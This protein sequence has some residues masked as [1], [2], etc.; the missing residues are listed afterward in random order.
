M[1]QQRFFNLEK[2]LSINRELCIAYHKFMSE[3]LDMSHVELVTNVDSNSQTY[4]LP[5]HAV[6]KE[7]SIT[8]KLRVVFDGSAPTSYGLSLNDVMLRG[9]IVQSSLFS[10]LLRFRVHK[11]ALTAILKKCII[12]Y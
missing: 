11:I 2:W 9:P 8:T 12:K 4:Y 6:I 10:I 5:H 3:Y 7:G 1:A